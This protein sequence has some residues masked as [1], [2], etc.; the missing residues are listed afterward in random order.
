[1]KQ[2]K[3][4]VFFLDIEFVEL[5]H[6][7]AITNINISNG[8]I[9]SEAVRSI[10]TTYASPLGDDAVARA[11]DGIQPAVTDLGRLAHLVLVD[12]DAEAWQRVAIDVAILVAEDLGIFEIVQKVSALIVVNSEALLL[13]DGVRRAV[14]KL[15]ARREQINISNE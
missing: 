4:W 5:S 6:G 10:A 2:K 1:M 7:E 11:P 9:H 12:S 13:N 3:N 14:V 15:Q 8:S